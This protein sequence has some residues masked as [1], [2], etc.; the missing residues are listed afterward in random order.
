MKI[1]KIAQSMGV[2]AKILN[3]YSTSKEN[4]YSCEYINN[5]NTY[6]TEEQRIGTWTKED[7]TQVP[8]YRKTLYLKPEISASTTDTSISLDFTNIDMMLIAPE[9]SYFIDVAGSSGKMP[10]PYLHSNT[11]YLVGGYINVSAG[12][13]VLNVRKGANIAIYSMVLTVNYTKTTD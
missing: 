8:L 2:V 3:S 5:L 4:T 12:K 10:F 1:K 9:A 7:G 11:N 6:S 13:P